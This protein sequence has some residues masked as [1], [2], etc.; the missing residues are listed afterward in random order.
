MDRKHQQDV[1]RQEFTELTS[2]ARL[3][4]PLL[5]FLGCRGILG[6][7]LVLVEESVTICPPRL[8]KSGR[9]A[10]ESIAHQP[11][12]VLGARLASARD[13]CGFE[14]RGRNAGPLRF[15][16]QRHRRGRPG[17]APDGRAA[18][19]RRGGLAQWAP[20]CQTSSRETGKSATGWKMITRRLKS[21]S[22]A[23]LGLLALG[24]MPAAAQAQPVPTFT[25]SPSTNVHVG[26]PVYF[27]ASSSVA[28]P[29]ATYSWSFGDG[30]TASAEDLYSTQ[31]EFPTPGTYTVTLTITDGT[32]T[33][34][35]SQ[36][37][38]V[39]WS[40]PSAAFTVNGQ[41][42]GDELPGTIAFEPGQALTFADAS[43]PGSA[44]LA[45]FVWSF[46][47]GSGTRGDSVTHAYSS[48]GI[49]SVIETVTD[50]NGQS[51][52]ASGQLLID[53]PPAAAFMVSPRAL[54]GHAV[55]FNA[56]GSHPTGPVGL[57]D[58][59]WDFGD[60]S[61][62]PADDGVP[63]PTPYAWDYGNSATAT[64]TYQSPGAYIVALDVTDA[65]NLAGQTSMT[66]TVARYMNQQDVRG[67]FTSQLARSPRFGKAWR[68][69]KTPRSNPS[70]VCP[71]DEIEH[72]ST[73][74]GGAPCQAEFA[75]KGKWYAVDGSVTPAQNSNGG[76][77][78]PTDTATI[79]YAHSWTRRWRPSSAKCAQGIPGKLYSNDGGCWDITIGQ[80]FGFVQP[81][82]SFK[83]HVYVLGTDTGDFPQWNE[84]TC[85]WSRGT[86]QCTSRF[87]DGFRW[88][89]Y[90]R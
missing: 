54:V 44:P 65:G 53:S 26:D 18:R 23:A 74:G 35:T 73:F 61:E 25:I 7:P 3:A 64:H 56:T 47:D 49:Y 63:L 10:E 62:P 38:N 80:N 1:G 29:D 34:R 40:P 70:P 12:S 58:F 30:D 50:T 39:S 46:G 60:G 72:L 77:A 75:Y 78:D 89:P 41:T 20:R 48:P 87:G 82:F 52:Q 67:D 13:S 55:S 84:L 81:K 76:I 42:L 69:S 32:G 68:G 2:D 31:E 59:S 11:I 36:N 15:S 85:S 16:Q 57:S 51:A 88:V 21:A 79:Y 37:V 4:H 6:R 43:S 28:Q 33:A 66:V 5:D 90:A 8:R 17:N 22:A 14:A 86:Y 9:H 71:R 27:D 24:V 19:K 83:R 45:S